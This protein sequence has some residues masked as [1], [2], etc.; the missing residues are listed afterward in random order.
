M[1]PTVAQ[2]NRLFFR[3]GLVWFL[4]VFSVPASASS[5]WFTR[6][7]K[8]D[9]GLLNN[10]II[11]VAQG[12]DGYLWVA[13]SV[14]L[15]R[16]DGVR[17]SRFPLE[18]YTGPID[19]H[20]WTMLCSRTGVLWIATTGGKV[21]AIQPDFS[22][23]AVPAN[24]LPKSIPLALAEDGEGALWVG[25]LHAI[26]RVKN[27][28]VTKFV[29]KEGVPRGGFHSLASDGAGN[30]WLAKGKHVCFFRDGKFRSV[31][32]AEGLK[33][34]AA[35]YSNTA[36]F[37]AGT[38]LFSCNTNGVVWNH[39]GIP[40]FAGA[41]KP[42]LEDRTG[43]IWIGTQHNGLFRYDSSG[44]EKVENCY[45]SI[46]GLVE[47]NEGN[48]WVSTDS[49]GLQRVSQAGVRKEVSENDQPLEEVRSICQDKHDVLW[50]ASQTGELISRIN[51]AWKAVFTNASFDGTVGCVAANCR[52]GIW[53]GTSDGKLLL[54]TKTNCT[55][56]TQ[57]RNHSPIYSLL[58]T[59]KG[60]LWIV[61]GDTLQCLR[62]GQLINVTLPRKVGRFSAI[63]E[64][65]EGNIWVGA[66]GIV[67]RIVN[68]KSGNR[69]SGFQVVNETPHL[70]ISNRNVCCLYATPDGSMWISC[71]GLGLMRLKNGRVS[72]IGVEQGLPNDY[73]AQ[74]VADGRGWL[75]FASDQG[76]FKIRQ[77]ELEQAMD[78]HNIR[79]RPIVYERNEGLMSLEALFST[80]GSFV[81]PRALCTRDGRIWLFT[82]TAL[83]SAN[84]KILPEKYPAPR[85]LLTRTVM[86]GKV[87]ADYGNVAATQTIANLKTLDTPLRLPP[88]F[89]HLEFDFTAFHFAAAENL[90]FRYQLTGFE[91]GWIDAETE[92]HADYSRLAAGNYQFRV[93]ASVGDGPWSKTPAV[94]TFI[95]LPFFWQTWWF[96]LGTLLLFTSSVIAIVRYISFRRL[97]TKMRLLEQRA[98]LERERMRIARDL[99]DDLGGSL[100][101]VAL[102]LDMTQREPG[103][104]ESLNGKIRRCSTVVRE[105]GKSVD[106]IVWAINPR[107]DTLRYMTDYLSQ[108]SVEFLHAANIPCRVDLPDYFPDQM[109]SPEARHNLLLVVKEAL[110][111]VIRHA[112]ATEVRLRVTTS[113]N[114]IIIS[115]ED[116]GRGFERSPD[117]ALCDGLNNMRQRMEEIGGQFQLTSHPGSGTRV[118]FL[119]SWSLQNG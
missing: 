104:G 41:T 96:R 54:L 55:T 106:E 45:C 24:S 10:N 97:Q 35:T 4:A 69:N 78:N 110:N 105:V 16:F 29:V 46:K 82:H 75:W 1:F 56:W 3:A 118:E 38:N 86:D 76:I 52:G 114:Q 33:C 117:N 115:I 81:F 2:L 28:Q 85:V 59:S 34:L 44:F 27:G 6:D 94:L 23:F 60:D 95:V 74:I 9:D 49:D 62:N 100:N 30:I 93:E 73:I 47:D 50:G 64:D 92:R 40:E 109:I 68:D 18:N 80:A 103:I 89:R 70:S 65:D 7:W 72:Q 12:R 88:R 101:M 53:I 21:I 61:S 26:V 98:A 119:Y 79:L 84:P 43:A 51:G 90:Q 87:I 5:S 20:I 66:R 25:Y 13:P 77:R 99:H 31:A 91:H 63:A 113:E 14:G 57:S 112:R 22:A 15:M 11:A 42:L 19:N 71:G 111:N 58:P 67:M 108:F 107:N 36:W 8:T 102:T 83:V 116:N 48:I 32:R 17:F 39:G 37:V